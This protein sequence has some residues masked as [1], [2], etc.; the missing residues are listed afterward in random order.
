[1]PYIHLKNE[2]PGILQAMTDYYETARPLSELA[3]LL[4]RTDEGMT[5]GER[6]LIAAYVSSL[7][8]CFFCS[9]SHLNAALA[10]LKLKPRMIEPG[11]D[12]PLEGITVRPVIQ[13][14][15]KIAG[16][17]Q[18]SGKIVVKEDVEAA[19]KE[20]ATDRMIHDTVLIAAAF[21]MYNRYVDGLNTVTPKDE[22]LYAGIGQMLAAKGYMAAIPKSRG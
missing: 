22:K 6:E 10:H 18:R 5:K 1:M 21:C 17:V 11:K 3:E 4:L 2:N 9:N 14:L 15:L 20:G 16:E 7:N 13:V 8:R 19:F 12:D